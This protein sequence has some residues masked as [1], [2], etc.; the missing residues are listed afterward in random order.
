MSNLAYARMCHLPS[1]WK[2]AVSFAFNSIIIFF[3]TTNTAG[4]YLNPISFLKLK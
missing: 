2:E 1:W 3:T 4:K